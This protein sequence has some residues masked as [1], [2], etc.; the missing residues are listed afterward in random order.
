MLINVCHKNT[1]E[2][3]ALL[4]ENLFHNSIFQSVAEAKYNSTVYVKF[5]LEHKELDGMWIYAGLVKKSSTTY[6]GIQISRLCENLIG[7]QRVGTMF[8]GSVLYV[9]FHAA[10]NEVVVRLCGCGLSDEINIYFL[11]ALDSKLKMIP[12][13]YKPQKYDNI[14]LYQL[15]FYKYVQ[16][17]YYKIARS[18]YH[19]HLNIL[20]SN[21]NYFCIFFF[22]YYFK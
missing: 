15:I 8:A 22:N 6:T 4:F 11:Y 17:L 21:C 10:F 14:T 18:R 12:L 20:N 9:C 5:S 3:L 2:K 7:V 19:H 16:Y 1:C 13:F